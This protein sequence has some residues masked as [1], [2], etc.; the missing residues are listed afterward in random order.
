M[1]KYRISFAADGVGKS[2][3]ITAESWGDAVEQFDAWVDG[4]DA[5][6]EMLNVLETEE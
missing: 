5:D 4:Q 1:N 3:T 6:I 2:M